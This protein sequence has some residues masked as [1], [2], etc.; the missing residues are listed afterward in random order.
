[1]TL[2]P[3]TFLESNYDFVVKRCQD[4]WIENPDKIMAS[5]IN[6]VTQL[7]LLRWDDD[8]TCDLIKEDLAKLVKED[9]AK[10]YPTAERVYIDLLF[11]S[12]EGNPFYVYA[13]NYFIRR[14]NS[15]DGTNISL[16]EKK[17]L[18]QFQ[19]LLMIKNIS[20]F[21]DFIVS[22]FP[23]PEERFRFLL[24]LS[25]EFSQKKALPGGVKISVSMVMLEKRIQALLKSTNK[26]VDEYFNDRSNSNNKPTAG[27][28]ALIIYCRYRNSPIKKNTYGHYTGGA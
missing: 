22:S 3:K 18:K 25:N 14:M 16:R 2:D 10:L 1:M 4:N 28:K 26:M 27:Q 15:S 8:K 9:L 17:F 24:L 6:I 12:V 7:E 5:L 19:E 21:E 11:R 23:K 20:V 13:T